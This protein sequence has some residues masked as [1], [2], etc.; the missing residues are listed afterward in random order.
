VALLVR[1]GHGHDRHELALAFDR[2]L[3]APEP[4]GIVQAQRG[5]AR[6]QGVQVKVQDVLHGPYAT[7]PSALCPSSPLF[8]I[9][10][11]ITLTIAKYTHFH[12]VRVH[13][14]NPRCRHR[15]QAISP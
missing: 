3:Q 13:L 11:K 5:E 12:H 2:G 4:G 14:C 10:S 1:L 8:A 7:F 9:T 15:N 6:N